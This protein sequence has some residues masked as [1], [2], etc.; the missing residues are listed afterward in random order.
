MY[1]FGYGSLINAASRQLT[2]QTGDAIPVVAKGLVRYWGKIDDSYIMSPLI[3]NQGEGE[4]S[5]VLLQVD[6]NELPNFD[7]REAG[8]QRIQI[9]ANQIETE[10]S[11]DTAQPIWVY[12]TDSYQQPC[13][14]SPIVQS[15]VDTV[16]AGCLDISEQFARHFIEHTVG[17][18]CPYE[19][20]R[21]A[22]K[23]QRVAGVKPH[24]QVSIDKL[25]TPV[26]SH[27]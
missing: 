9:N 1:I 23:Y 3:V 5:G 8:Y 22:P 7:R 14:N 11:F 15:Y 4:V 19:N 13:S 10:Y 12:V 25:L 24:H 17:W 18:H 21:Q 6:D 26:F 27:S 20:D 16:I 2:G